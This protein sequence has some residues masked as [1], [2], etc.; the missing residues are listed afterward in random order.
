MS[1]HLDSPAARQ[2]PRLDI[3]D[4]YVFRGER[5]TVFVTNHSHSL[6]GEDI[7][8][9]LHPEG[10]YEFKIDGNGDA[11]EDLTY[12]FTFSDA[13]ADG[14]QGYELRRL[15]GPEARDAFAAGTVIARGRT[16]EAA[17]LAGGGRVWVGKAGDPFWIEPDVLHAVGHAFQDGTIVDLSSWNP[18]GAKNLF[19][20]H[21]VYSIVLEVTDEELL[22]VAGEDHRIGVWGL[23]WLATDA[24]G[25]RPINRAGLPMIH[26]LFT[27]FDEDLGDRLNENVP[28]DDVRIHGKLLTDMVA[29]VVRAYGNAEDPE[30]YA[31]TVVSRILPNV[32]P[33]TVGTPAA[34]GFAEWN[35]RS[36][37]DNAPDVMFSFASN[38]PVTLGIGKESVTAK[39]SSVFP[40]VP[41]AS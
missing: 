24:G 38:T 33:Y 2:D 14:A 6:A 27:Q 18:A 3:T 25:W 40:Y 12:R 5:G 26:P 22:P 10:R 35:G 20:G 31:R 41:S 16:G 39:P 7:P 19:A 37:T 8:R 9:G 30:A 29:G 13:D 36:L 23:T 1:H 34:Y 15:A 32:L 21:T 4:L 17:E 11:V 28:A